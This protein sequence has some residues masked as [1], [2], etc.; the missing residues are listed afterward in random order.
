MRSV[1]MYLAVFLLIG[2]GVTGC[3]P[4]NGQVTYMTDNH[5]SG[6]THDGEWARSIIMS[7]WYATYSEIFWK[8]KF[9][10][11]KNPDGWEMQ[12]RYDWEGVVYDWGGKNG[13]IE[14]GTKKINIKISD[15]RY[16][17]SV[18][19]FLSQPEH[20]V[21]IKE[22]IYSDYTK[23]YATDKQEVDEIIEAFYIIGVEGLQV[24]PDDSTFRIIDTYIR[25]G[26]SWEKKGEYDKAISEYDKA[27]D[28][29]PKYSIAYN[30]F[31][32]LLATVEN[33]NY[34]DGLKAEKLAK[35]AVE[36]KRT[37]HHL[38]T[39]AAALAENGNFLDAVRVEKEAL[40]L[41]TDPNDIKRYENLIRVYQGKR[42]YAQ[43]KYGN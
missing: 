41:V 15:I 2:L 31:A 40:S 12:Y 19:P 7:A 21:K 10:W 37:A 11:I 29:Y 13:R 6:S 43:Y 26:N 35:K 4:L 27:I 1:V 23:F 14:K 22:S 16:L 5:Y 42:T 39:L 30:S 34:R 8:P 18:T 28:L 24:L 17:Y 33:V 9:K 20:Q 36:L 32:W 3:A 38:D 25:K